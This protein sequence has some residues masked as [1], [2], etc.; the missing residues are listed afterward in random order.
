MIKIKK[1]VSY[2]STL[3]VTGHAV[4]RFNIMR[5]GKKWMAAKSELINPYTH[6][7]H[8]AFVGDIHGS[9]FRCKRWVRKEAKKLIRESKKNE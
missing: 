5:F 4:F 6:K 7:Q 3:H 8:N 2:Q 9:L 1:I